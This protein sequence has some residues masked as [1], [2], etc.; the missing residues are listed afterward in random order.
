[1]SP[2]YYVIRVEDNGD[3]TV[4]PETF[5]DNGE[6]QKYAL[7]VIN[8]DRAQGITS[9]YYRV[10]IAHPSPSITPE[11]YMKILRSSI[12]GKHAYPYTDT[13]SLAVQPQRADFTMDEVFP[14]H[15]NGYQTHPCAECGA[16]VNLNQMELHVSWH[17][18]LLP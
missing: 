15:G 8:A 6:A 5:E 18:K 9:T 14:T 4:M 16:L 13:D 10:D 11:Q 2:I 1:M 12:Y 7:E 3:E 17:N